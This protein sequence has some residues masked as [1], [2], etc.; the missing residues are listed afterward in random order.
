VVTR[1]RLKV[2]DHTISIECVLCSNKMESV[3]EKGHRSWVS[4]RVCLGEYFS[5]FETSVQNASRATRNATILNLMNVPL[6]KKEMKILSDT[7]R[8]VDT[9]NR[10]LPLFRNL[11]Y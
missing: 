11:E 4:E 1:F 8:F 7:C 9:F 10:T 3:Y 2:G 6:S 5:K